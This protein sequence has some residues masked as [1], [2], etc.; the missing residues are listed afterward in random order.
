MPRAASPG[1]RRCAVVAVATFGHGG[2]RGTQRQPAVT[3]C[4]SWSTIP[5]E[6]FLLDFRM[7]VRAGAPADWEAAKKFEEQ[8]L[9]SSTTTAAED[10]AVTKPRWPSRCHA[11]LRKFTA[12][13]DCW[14]RRLKPTRSPF[15]ASAPEPEW[16]SAKTR[17]ESSGHPCGARTALG[18]WMTIG[19]AQCLEMGIPAWSRRRRT[20]GSRELERHRAGAG[21]AQE[22]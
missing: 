6:G 13:T 18:A 21:C 8:A 17:L 5:H 11:T 3:V 22:P 7:L 4:R 1:S 15:E 12:T 9:R 10:P 2:P 20:V 14:P 16:I 19:Q